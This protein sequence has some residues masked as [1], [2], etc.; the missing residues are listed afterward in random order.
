MPG[1]LYIYS[2]RVCVQEYVVVGEGERG[3]SSSPT[4]GQMNMSGALYISSYVCVCSSVMHQQ[5]V[6]VGK[7]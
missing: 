4:N 5:C 7:G 2:W 6:V 3:I 1:A